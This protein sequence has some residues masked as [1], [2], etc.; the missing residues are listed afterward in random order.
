MFDDF[1]DGQNV[2]LLEDAGE[3]DIPD[4]L[5]CSGRRMIL[6]REEHFVLALHHKRSLRCVMIMKI[7][8]KIIASTHA[9][10]K[11]MPPAAVCVFPLSHSFTIPPTHAAMPIELSI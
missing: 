8:I 2:L 7:A 5:A 4:R 1:A 11:S 10:K 6:T 3:D 9:P